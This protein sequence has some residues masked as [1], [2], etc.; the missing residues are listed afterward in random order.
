MTIHPSEQQIRDL[1]ALYSVYPE[2]FYSP[3]DSSYQSGWV[4]K[5][6]RHMALAS[7]ASPGGMPRGS[8]TCFYMSE[9]TNMHDWVDTVAYY[10]KLWESKDV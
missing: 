2:P 7:K 5:R 10:A 9:P 3:V 4:V 8:S 6:Y 1:C